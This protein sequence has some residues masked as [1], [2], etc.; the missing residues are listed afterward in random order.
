MLSYVHE[1]LREVAF[2]A[3]DPDESAAVPVVDV[4]WER[5]QNLLLLQRDLA[6]YLREI[7]NPGYD[8]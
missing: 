1:R 2:E 4:P 8:D 5:W 3:I 6:E 7:A